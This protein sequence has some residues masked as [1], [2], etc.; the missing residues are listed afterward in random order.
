MADTLGTKFTID[1]TNLKA[2]LAQAN[3]MIRESESEF[4]A[5]AAGMDNWSKSQEGLEKRIKT[6]N[7]ITAI[8]QQKVDALKTEYKRLIDNGLDPT[9]KKASD[10]RIEINKNEEALNKN[11]REAE[12]CKEQLKKVGDESTDTAKEIDTMTDSVSKS[13]DGY[14]VFKDVLA[15]FASNALNSVVS[16]LKDAAKYA[17]DAYKAVDE[18]AD[19]VIKQTGATGEVAEK[20][21]QSYKNVAR[22]IKGDFTD[23]GNTLGQVNTRFGYTGT[24]LE[25]ATKRFIQFADITGVDATEAVRLV[26]RALENAGDELD[27]YDILLDKIAKASQAS[28]VSVTTLAEGLVKN[29]AAMRALGFDT[30]ETIAL[31]AQFEK[32]GVNT[33][34]AFKGMQT[35][36]KEWSSEGK[37]AKVEFQKMMKEIENAPSDIDRSKLAFDTFGKKAGQE[38]SDAIGTGRFSYNNFV[39]DIKNS[40]G[41][42]EDTYT[43]VKDGIDD[44]DVA[45]QDLK[46][47]MGEIVD[48][49]DKEWGSKISTFIHAA[50]NAI[51]LLPIAIE[52]VINSFKKLFSIAEVGFNGIVNAARTAWQKITD[53]FGGTSFF[54]NPNKV[55]NEMISK[56]TGYDN[57]AKNFQSD[58]PWG[59]K[60]TSSSSKQNMVVVPKLALGG[61]VRGATQAII[62]ESGAEAVVP[63]ERNTEWIDILAEKLSKQMGGGVT[64]NQTNNYSQEHSRY[65]ILKSQQDTVRAV[66]LALAGGAL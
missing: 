56:M 41:T 9:S 61:V 57:F 14:T 27:N 16:G 24:K 53:W 28:G 21:Q 26:A 32:A 54:E 30:D 37:D 7:D 40:K 11:T 50:A 44:I 39:T 33:E 34:T 22:K 62:G 23:I 51:R 29:G 64:V 25:Q 36:A 3:R 12:K 8:Q 42:V 45:M 1:V 55:A 15:D 52:G 66:K 10:L 2:G 38:L 6:L 13:K 35:A 17:M 48:K 5:A 59:W 65:E 43:A 19:A 49:M 60:S 58:D 4:R 20:L 18:G 31:F 46:L 63:L 47:A